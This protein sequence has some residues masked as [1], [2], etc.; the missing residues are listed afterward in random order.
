MI[1]LNDSD[2]C[3]KQRMLALAAK[4]CI[5]KFFNLLTPSIPIFDEQ[6]LQRESKTIMIFR[7]LQL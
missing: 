2:D 4:W 3:K 5:S 6:L 1:W 7:R